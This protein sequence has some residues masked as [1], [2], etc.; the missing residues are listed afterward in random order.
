MRE[1][2][3]I[4]ARPDRPPARNARVH[5]TVQQR[6]QVLDGRA[7]DAGETFRQHVRPKGHRGAHCPDRQG[8]V[9]PGG[10]ASEQVQ[11]ERAERVARDGGLSERAEA[12]IDA[13]DRLASVCGTVD[14]LAR[15]VYPA[16]CVRRQRHRRVVVGNRRQLFQGER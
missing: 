11:L 6:Q 1:R 10:M 2:G 3:E 12:G 9:D 4:A 16:G 14:H 5:P 13:V 8:L 7:P 15:C